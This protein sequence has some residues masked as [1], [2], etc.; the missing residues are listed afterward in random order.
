MRK[1][2]TP[3]RQKSEPIE[4]TIQELFC[5]MAAFSGQSIDDV[6]RWKIPYF[7][8]MVKTYN[9]DLRLRQVNL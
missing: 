2:Q 1:P 5:L 6:K 3:R 4:F 9:K 8:K 7:L